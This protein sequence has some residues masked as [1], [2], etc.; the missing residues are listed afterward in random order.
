MYIEDKPSLEE[1]RHFGKLGMRWGTRRGQK[2]TDSLS[3]ELDD[4]MKDYDRG[5]KWVDAGSFR[6]LSRRTR[7]LSY[8]A[9]KRIARM[10]KYLNRVKDENV[11][12]ILVKWERNPEKVKQVKDYL[13]KSQ[14]QTK[15]LSEMRTSLIDIKI[16]ML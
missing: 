4:T 16:D 10:N 13:A 9:N 8:K 3:R 15:K 6:E 14:L 1:L 7:K 5:S 2:K 11:N 12:N